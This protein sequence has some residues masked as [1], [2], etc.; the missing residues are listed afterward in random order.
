MDKYFTTKNLGWAFSLFCAFMLIVSGISKISAFE[1]MVN[2]FSHYNL[3]PYLEMVGIIEIIGAI[4]LLYPKTSAYGALIVSC[5]M[6]GAVAIHI[7][8]Y[9]GDHFMIPF[10]L[11]V[12][13]WTGHCLRK[14]KLS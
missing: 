2:N 11:G 7:S 13:A 5:V 12:S 10:M 14:Y 6:S 9:A 4:L 8:Y 3:L 1:P